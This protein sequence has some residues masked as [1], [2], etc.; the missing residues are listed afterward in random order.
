MTSHGIIYSIAYIGNESVRHRYHI[1]AARDCPVDGCPEPD[2][3]S[4]D[5]R[6][7][8]FSS[9]RLARMALATIICDGDRYIEKT[10]G[11]I[12]ATGD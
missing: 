7:A 2:L 11:F 10:Q 1:V 4:I 12:Q 5:N 8:K 9:L 6:P 3:V